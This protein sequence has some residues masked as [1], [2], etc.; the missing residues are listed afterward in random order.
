MPM[1]AGVSGAVFDGDIAADVLAG[2][3]RQAREHCYGHRCT[4]QSCRW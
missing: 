1:R 3:E 2:R 4:V